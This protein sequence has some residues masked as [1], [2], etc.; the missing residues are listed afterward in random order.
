MDRKL[1]EKMV[2]LSQKVN[3]DQTDLT[4][5]TLSAVK[6]HL[7]ARGYRADLE[8]VTRSHKT[9]GM[10]FQAEIKF[11]SELGYPTEKDVMAVTAQAAPDHDI[12]WESVDVDTDL[13]IVYL[14]LEP[15][16]E[17]I[18]VAN[19][20]SIPGEFISVGA[21][22]YKRAADASDSMMEIWSLQKTDNG[23]ALFRNDDIDVQA[24]E[25]DD[26]FKAGDV[27][28]TPNGP[29]LIKRLDDLGNAFVQIG[30]T[31]RLVGA[32]DMEKYNINKEKQKLVDYYT[33]V[34]GNPDFG[35]ALVEEYGDKPRK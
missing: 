16:V 7:Q 15:S 22:L 32:A 2:A 27:V 33:R 30:R 1:A 19:I 8:F 35:R 26:G 29:G 3:K 31:L 12:E 23:L 24:D 9:A 13:G 28:D 34:Y 10:R 17:M 18:P 4:K 20:N 6:K 11:D 5:Q 25:Q 14:N 21:G